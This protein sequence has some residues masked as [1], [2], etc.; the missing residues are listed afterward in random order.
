MCALG[1]LCLAIVCYSYADLSRRFSLYASSS[2]KETLSSTDDALWSG[3]KSA[4]FCSWSTHIT[5][6]TLTLPPQNVSLSPL[7]Q[8]VKGYVLRGQGQFL[9]TVDRWRPRIVRKA[10][11]EE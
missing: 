1:H 6:N 8:L 2:E 10:R 4:S 3:I 11:S 9:A 5:R 7:K